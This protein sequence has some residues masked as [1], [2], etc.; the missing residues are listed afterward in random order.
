MDEFEKEA[1]DWMH[2]NAVR[3]DDGRVVWVHK[4]TVN[5]LADKMRE[6]VKRKIDEAWEN[7]RERFLHGLYHIREIEC[8]EDHDEHMEPCPRRTAKEAIDNVPCSLCKEARR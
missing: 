4:K 5:S 1:R 7:N 3:E 2:A 6:L 8:T